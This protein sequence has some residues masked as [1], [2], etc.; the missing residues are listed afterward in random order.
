MA[1][2]QRKWT[3]KG[4]EKSAWVVDYFDAKGKRRLKTFKTKRAADDWRSK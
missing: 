1:I 2:R 4:K 3:W